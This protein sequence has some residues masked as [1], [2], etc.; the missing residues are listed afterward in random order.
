VAGGASAAVLAEYEQALL[1]RA[2][3]DASGTTDVA[4]LALLYANFGPATW[5]LDLNVDGIV[6]AGDAMAFITQL[7]RTVPGDYNLDGRVDAADYTMWRDHLG[8]SGGGLIA[9]V[10]NAD[11]EVWK[12]AFGFQRGPFMAGAA[13]G[14]AAVPEPAAVVLSMLMVSSFVGGSRRRFFGGSSRGM[15]H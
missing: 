5:L 3:L 13:N 4:D 6:D 7:V 15:M 8:Q 2:D 12:A 10:D 9:D 1:R 11:Y 14:A